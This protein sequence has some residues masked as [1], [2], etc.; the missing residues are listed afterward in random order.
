[1]SSKKLF[2]ALKKTTSDWTKQRK[3]EEREA[4]QRHNRRINLTK[5]SRVTVKEAAWEIMESGN[6]SGS[7]KNIAFPA[8]KNG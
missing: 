5:S 7:R 3:R 4:I 1:M 2:D 8:V 6:C